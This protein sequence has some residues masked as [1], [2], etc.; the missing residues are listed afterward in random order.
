M[1]GSMFEGR[2][3]EHSTANQNAVA[4]SAISEL[5]RNGFF[6]TDEIHE[7]ALL[8]F[9]SSIGEIRVDIRS[10][11]PIRD[12][13]PQSSQEAKANTLSSRYGME[14][15]P[16]HTDVAHWTDPAHV[17]VLHCSNPGSGDRPTHIQDSRAW[18]LEPKEMDAILREVWKAGHVHP[19]LCT[20][21]TK[22]ADGMCIRFDEACMVPMTGPA[23]ELAKQIATH[24]HLTPTIDVVWSVGTT[25]V[26][27][28]RR[29]L[30]ARGRSIRP[31]TDR[32]VKR[33][34]VGGN[35]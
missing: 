2:V 1:G 24:V 26:V 25:L 11:E 33:I 31:D 23:R 27:D 35:N 19:R 17:V 18:N 28:N 20:I 14:S 12:I 22:S 13:R 16:F 21:G 29:M 32:I 8:Q 15:F 4:E 30:H 34:L 9:A 3:P 6:I 7:G 10:P 5:E